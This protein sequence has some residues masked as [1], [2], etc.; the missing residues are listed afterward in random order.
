M[1][2]TADGT[3]AK[4][5][6]ANDLT[7]ADLGRALAAGWADFRSFPA[8]GLFFAAF[9][10]VA[11][12]ALWFVL[13]QRGQ[14]VWLVPAA[15]FPLIAPFTAVGMYEASRRREAGLPPDWRAVLNAVRGRGD[16][17]VLGVGVVA[18]V[19]FCFWVII[20]H[21]IFYIFMAQ[22]GMTSESMAFFATPAGVAMLA[23]GTAVGAG[24]ALLIFALTAISLP[25]LVD[26]DMDC[27]TAMVASVAAVR[28]N[29]A[30]MLGW[31]ALIAVALFA[32]MLPAL[33]GLLLAL[34]LFAHA[35]WHLYRRAAA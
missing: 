33:L 8:F 34:P 4:L 9:Y 2:A 31:A 14:W 25:M 7:F 28:S 15:G 17:Q 23:F 20:G 10:V 5:R 1:T 32:A 13:V 21:G 12:W 18:F 22:A 29:R 6:V 26:R 3:S 19:I 16:G 11:G 35:S 24:F 27:I 30:V